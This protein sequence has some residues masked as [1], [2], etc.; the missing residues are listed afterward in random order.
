MS[1][2]VASLSREEAAAD[3][4]VLWEEEYLSLRK[5]LNRFSKNQDITDWKVRTAIHSLVF[6]TMRRL[7][8]ID[9]VLDQVLSRSKLLNLD[10]FTRN[11]LRV[12]TYLI[13][14]GKGVAALATNEAVTIIKRRRSRKLG[15]FINAVLRKVQLFDFEKLLRSLPETQSTALKFSVPEWLVEYTERLLGKE[16]AHAFLSSGLENPPVYVRVNTLIGSIAEVKQELEKEGFECLSIPKIPEIF[17]LKKGSRP[18]TKTSTYQR[19]AIY[20]QNLASVIVGRVVNPFPQTILVDLCAAP[21]SKTSHLAQLMGNKGNIISLDWSTLRLR[22]FEK[23]L[24]RQSVRNT[25]IILADGMSLPFKEEFRA[26]CVLVDPPCSSTGVLQT[27]PEVKWG[28]TLEIVSRMSKIQLALFKQGSKLVASDGH[29]VYS[30]C[31]I[32]KE[33]NEDVIRKFLAN[34]PEFETVP[35]EPWIGSPAFEGLTNCQR[36]F[37]HRNETEGFFIAK[38]IRKQASSGK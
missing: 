6:E 4:L 28:L 5:A 19:S 37:P 3:V 27:R 34:N 32:T 38:M 9:W 33:E 11:L 35:T 30:T 24:T 8:T 18:V 10:V 1:Y 2:L 16:E 22:E 21:G 26:D 29:I 7:N 31:S 20:L 23:V 14:S 17:R 12:A 25:H 15:G 36:L 13:F